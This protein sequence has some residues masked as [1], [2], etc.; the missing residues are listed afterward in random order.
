MADTTP[1]T[2]SG[3]QTVDSGLVLNK[4]ATPLYEQ[5]I[6]SILSNLQ[7]GEGVIE[8][9]VIEVSQDVAKAW[10]RAQTA[11]G[12]VSSSFQVFLDED[13]LK[14]LNDL[15]ALHRPT[16]RDELKLGMAKTMVAGLTSP[17]AASS[18]TPVSPPLSDI[19]Q[20]PPAPSPEG[21]N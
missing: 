4:I 9:L 20:T 13:L 5:H 18:D 14:P 6:Q 7:L 12:D 8:T 1:I 17:P 15:L 3:D 10:V 2:P 21:E 19:D 16:V 11:A